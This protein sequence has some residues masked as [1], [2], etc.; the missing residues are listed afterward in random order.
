MIRSKNAFTLIELLV[1]IAI[2]AILAALLLPALS[3]SKER[4][5]S[6]YCKNNLRQI[7]I[8]YTIATEEN[9]GRFAGLVPPGS[10]TSYSV[11]MRL[12]VDQYPRYEWSLYQW[13]NG[14]PMWSCP[15]APALK[16][17]IDWRWNGTLRH[18]W[19]W[20]YGISTTNREIRNASY[21]RNGSL[22]PDAF[23]A[24]GFESESEVQFPTKTPVWGDGS[25]MEGFQFADT[26][27][28]E[29]WAWTTPFSFRV[30]FLIPRH[31][32]RPANIVEIDPTEKLP[33]AINLDYCDGHVEQIPL[34]KVWSQYW[35]ADYVPPAKRPGLK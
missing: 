11:G 33:G 32:S 23:G 29:S 25:L 1:V 9:S 30:S 19:G 6:A 14:N 35:Y 15:N 26:S 31:G 20:S 12:F 7:N 34:E 2:I 8:A 22:S 18:G 4:A 3:S 21:T 28:P 10:Y 24:R 17:P 13:A 16:E 5:R 27:P